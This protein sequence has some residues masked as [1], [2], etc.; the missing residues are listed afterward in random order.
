M[1]PITHNAAHRAAAPKHT[2]HAPFPFFVFFDRSVRFSP[3]FPL[4][5]SGNRSIPMLQPPAHT[6]PTRRPSLT[7][8]P[9][10]LL[11]F[12]LPAWQIVQTRV[13]LYLHFSIYHQPTTPLTIHWSSSVILHPLR[14]SAERGLR[15]LGSGHASSHAE[16][17]FQTS[18][19]Y[20]K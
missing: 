1:P 19:E 5:L 13:I 20:G 18:P 2:V 16:F 11:Y 4:W 15:S 8:S 3:Y 9:L 10:L 7:F 12:G 14:L 17:F 6:T